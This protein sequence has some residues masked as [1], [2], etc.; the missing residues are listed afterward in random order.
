M[1]RMLLTER[2]AS[3]VTLSSVIQHLTKKRKLDHWATYFPSFSPA[4]V[5]CPASCAVT[6][7]TSILKLPSAP[8]NGVTATIL[9]M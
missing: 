3:S 8:S 9:R 6:F 7:D 5:S 4:L 2:K 1:S